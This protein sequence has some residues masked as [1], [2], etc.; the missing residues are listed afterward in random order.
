[1]FQVIQSI[2]IDYESSSFFNPSSARSPFLLQPPISHSRR[3]AA[4]RFFPSALL[5]K[6]HE[7]DSPALS[8]CNPPHAL[9]CA[10]KWK[11]RRKK[12]SR[13]NVSVFRGL[14]LQS[15]G[16]TPNIRIFCALLYVF[17][18]WPS[19]GE[20]T[21]L[22]LLAPLSSQSLLPILPVFL[23]LFCSSSAGSSPPSPGAFWCFR[24]DSWAQHE[25]CGGS[26]RRDPGSQD[27][28]ERRLEME[29]RVTR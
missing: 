15:G 7:N 11:R 24:L 27:I 9:F 17:R 10:N 16:R 21:L 25:L 23:P 13:D 22:I 8:R 14:H 19:C 28:R 2:W 4:L 1:M 6:Y 29:R 26:A 20:I 3:R 5:F 18:E 12:K